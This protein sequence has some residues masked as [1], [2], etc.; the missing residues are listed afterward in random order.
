V[1]GAES[2]VRTALAAGV[3]VCFANPGTTEM[4]LVRALDA[5]GG[6]RPVLGLFEGVCS[7]AAD[8]YA[9]MAGRPALV[10]LHLGPGLGNAVANLHNARK[11]R[12]PVV[13]VVGDHARTHRGR[14]APLEADVEGLAG[15]VSG[16]VRT[17]A[18]P[19][20]VAGDLAEAIG[21]ARGGGVATLVVPTDCAWGEARAAAQPVPAAPRG[22]VAD[23][24]VAEAADL[25]ARGACV[26]LGEAGLGERALAAAARLGCPVFAETFPS[27]ME[28]GGG[29]H[30]P[31][32][33]P[34]FPQDATAALAASSGVVLAGAPA[35]VAFFAYPGLPA[36]LAPAGTPVASLASPGEDVADA[37]ERL[38]ERVGG[39]PPAAPPPAPVA[40]PGGRLTPANVGPAI[41]AAQPAGA[42]VV[43]E[44]ITLSEPY[45]TASA[46]APRH[47]YLALTGGAI[48]DGLPMAVGAAVACPHRPVLVLQADGSG[49][50]TPQALWTMA[51]E[52]LDVVV[53]V[54]ANRVYRIL[55]IELA[56]AG[57]ETPGAAARALTGLG[58]P[59]VDWVALAAGFGVRG[60]RVETTQELARALVE[61]GPRVVEAA[62]DAP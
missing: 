32:R 51:R 40:P 58:S 28:R 31:R 11:G 52:G 25:L 46:G 48:G 13:V 43:D 2:L 39:A 49:L 37:L 6:V 24:A 22:R 61:P 53:V 5:V 1:T 54:L 7:G 36:E 42:I 30:A 4:D 47:T 62:L 16:W 41:A 44:A 29:L 45:V 57:E 34:Y 55:E 3:E 50:Y 14:G 59:T 18:S 8:G 21:F 20:A 33:L 9:R 56:R 26:L 12:T 23:A 35:P 19:D 15:P 10:L 38:A 60:E 27:R 17:S